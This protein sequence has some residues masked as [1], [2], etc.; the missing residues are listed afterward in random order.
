M[1]MFRKIQIH[2]NFKI[3]I[4]IKLLCL[5]KAA[6]MEKIEG[7]LEAD[8]ITNFIARKFKYL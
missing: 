7:L 3:Y 1:E 6:S 5:V 4:L 8:I 2:N